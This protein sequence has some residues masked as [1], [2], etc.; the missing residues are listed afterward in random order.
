MKTVKYN[1]LQEIKEG[2]SKTIETIKNGNDKNGVLITTLFSL[3]GQTSF[4]VIKNH[5]TTE[6]HIYE[7]K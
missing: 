2:R 7:Q 6:F 3:R 4:R 5:V 1:T